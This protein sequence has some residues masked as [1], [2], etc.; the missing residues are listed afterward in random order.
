VTG[1]QSV[2]GTL[3]RGA[4][5]GLVAG[6]LGALVLLALRSGAGVPLLA[7]LLPDRVLPHLP[8]DLFLEVIGKFGGTMTSKELAYWGGFP[9]ELGAGAVA[10]VL[11]AT[12]AARGRPAGRALLAAVAT[13]WLVVLA[14]LWPVLDASYLGLPAL[15][16]RVATAAA[17]LAAFLAVAGCLVGTVRLLGIPPRRVESG[18]G[19]AEPGRRAVLVAGGGA[20]LA[21]AAGGLALRLF[22]DGAF[23]YD[24]TRLL[25]ARRAPIT[26]AGDFYVVTKNLIDP[27]VDASLWRLEVAGDVQRPLTLDLGRLRQLGG[28]TQETT[29]ECISNGVGYGLLSNALWT[30]LP[31]AQLL[32]RAGVGPGAVQVAL[33]G[34]DGYVHTLALDRAMRGHALVAHAMNGAPLTRRHGSPARAVVPGAYGEVSV[35]WLT[36]VTVRSSET[37]GYYELQGWQPDHVHTTSVVDAPR[38]GQV[39]RLSELPVVQVHGVAFAGDRG[40]RSVDFSWDDGATWHPARLDYQRSPLAWALWSFEWAPP[41]PGRHVLT[42]RATDGRGTPQETRSHGF[43]PA[44]AS[45]L[46]RVR[47]T[48]EA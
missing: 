32:A 8:V 5:A 15:A 21:A 10:G 16:G 9:A 24:G 25:P 12:L 39:L 22:Q 30:G 6:L 46:H 48:V 19:R 35:K 44:G 27:D 43:A 34:A 4:A 42:A 26:P 28:T 11:T 33:H 7:E 18:A 3:L 17:L 40:I 1:T 38:G 31:L 37:Q 29:L 20:L 45:G 13:V 41:G 2:K 36:R 23:V 47:V 14:G